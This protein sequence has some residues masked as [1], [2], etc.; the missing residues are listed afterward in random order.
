[1]IYLLWGLAGWCGTPWP[2][3]WRWKWPPPPPPP[4]PWWWV[5]KIVA[6]I[7]GEV[8]GWL[9]DRMFPGTAEGPALVA[10]S[11]LGA[12]FVGRFVAEVV[13]YAGGN[14]GPAARG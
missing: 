9:V 2:W 7:G 10:A 3:W 8:G 5:I 13:N 12:F 11:T 4:D 14:K 6:V 1:M